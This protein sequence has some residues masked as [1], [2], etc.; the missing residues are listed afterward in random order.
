MHDK[1]YK[2]SFQCRVTNNECGFLQHQFANLELQ[3]LGCGIGLVDTHDTALAHLWFKLISDC[4]G[5]FQYFTN[6]HLLCPE[7]MISESGSWSTVT[8]SQI[9]EYVDHEWALT[10]ST[11]TV[12]Q[13]CNPQSY[14]H[15]VT[16]SP[17]TDS[18]ALNDFPLLL[19]CS[20]KQMKN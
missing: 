7:I 9:S 19:Q 1:T 12:K 2:L 11:S 4:N 5:F 17:K 20:N 15:D 8:L 3:Y 16:F 14:V 18:I 10:N 13:C 6:R